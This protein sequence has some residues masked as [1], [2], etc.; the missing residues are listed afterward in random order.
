KVVLVPDQGAIEELTAAGLHPPLHDRVHS[1]HPYT[2]EHHLDPRIGQDGI[3]QPGELPVPVPDQE[4]RP[5][6]G[7]LKIHDQVPG[8]LGH[9]RGSRCPFTPSPR[10]RRKWCSTTVS[11]N[12]RAPRTVSTWTKSAA[13]MPRACAV[14]PCFQ[15]GP[16]RRGAGSIPAACR[17]CHTVEAAIGWP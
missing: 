8:G 7:I 3:E 16:D 17:I 1:W 4:P 15:V 5:A 13:R 10:I 9:P 11:T 6:S 2:G 12:M 14:R